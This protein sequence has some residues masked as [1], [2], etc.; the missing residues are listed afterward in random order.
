LGTELGLVTAVSDPF[1]QTSS[2][3][4]DAFDTALGLGPTAVWINGVSVHV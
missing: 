4:L 3:E 2:S 1:N